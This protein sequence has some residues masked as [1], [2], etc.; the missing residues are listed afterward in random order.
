VTTDLDAL[1]TAHGGQSVEG[2]AIR[3][4]QRILAMSA[5]IWHNNK[6]GQPITRPLIAFDH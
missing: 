6:T 3:V 4:A 5:G 1:I 2:A